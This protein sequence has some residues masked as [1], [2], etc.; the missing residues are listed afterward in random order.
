MTVNVF[1]ALT[2]QITPKKVYEINRELG[3][4]I[5]KIGPGA[6]TKKHYGFVIYGE[7]TNDKFCCKLV[8]FQWNNML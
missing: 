3:Q 1:K 7:M 5:Y 6:Y 4:K 2:T 8:S